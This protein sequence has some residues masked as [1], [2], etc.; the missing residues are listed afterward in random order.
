MCIQASLKSCE[1]A[2]KSHPP[3]RHPRW[4]RMAHIANDLARRPRHSHVTRECVCVPPHSILVVYQAL[5]TEILE[6]QNNTNLPSP[7]ERTNSPQ[8]QTSPGLRCDC[9]V[10]DAQGKQPVHCF[11]EYSAKAT[12]ARFNHKLCGPPLPSAAGHGS[13]GL[14][15]S[16]SQ[17][18]RLDRIVFPVIRSLAQER[19][20]FRASASARFSHVASLKCAGGRFAVIV[21]FRRPFRGFPNPAPAICET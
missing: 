21:R 8:P 3:R 13:T 9:V 2:L 7:P 19:E 15:F 6:P 1:T 17:K 14:W 10:Q 5:L 16:F 12:Q 18:E 4:P 11:V 20:I